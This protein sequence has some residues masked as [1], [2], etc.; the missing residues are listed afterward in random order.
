MKTQ[1]L[2]DP[3]SEP[4]TGHF[5]YILVTNETYKASTDPGEGETDSISL[6]RYGASLMAKGRDLL[7]SI[8]YIHNIFY[9]NIAVKSIS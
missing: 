7:Q 4:D 1:S 9:E 8:K 3:V 5:W 6:V 2:W